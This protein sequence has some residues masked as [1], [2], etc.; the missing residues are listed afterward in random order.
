MDSAYNV[1]ES[2]T[3]PACTFEKTGFHFVGWSLTSNGDIIETDT[4]NVTEDVEL[5]AIWEEDGERTF[6]S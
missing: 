2:Y 6:T 3:L 4:I 5:F 1:I